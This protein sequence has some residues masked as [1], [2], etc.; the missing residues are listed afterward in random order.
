[1]KYIIHNAADDFINPQR[2][3]ESA[4]F[5]TMKHEICRA[6]LA[7]PAQTLKFFCSNQIPN[8]LVSNMNI[9]VHGIFEH[10]FFRKFLFCIFHQNYRTSF[11]PILTIYY[12]KFSNFL[13][14]IV[15]VEAGRISGAAF[16]GGMHFPKTARKSRKAAKISMYPHPPQVLLDKND[17]I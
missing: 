7:D 15:V 8:H 1:V 9:S 5:R 11:L 10:F 16:G 17:Y 2:M 12:K 4:M 6:Q 14:A 13:H 3:I